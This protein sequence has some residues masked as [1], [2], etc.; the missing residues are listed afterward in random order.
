MA[1]ESA[2]AQDFDKNPENPLVN[3]FLHYLIGLEQSTF[4]AEYAYPLSLEPMGGV[5]NGLTELLAIDQGGHFLALERVY[6]IRGFEVKLFQLATGGAMDISTLPSL[7]S[8]ENLNPIQKQLVL[9]FSTL[10][11]PVDAVD[12]L[13]A[14]TLG[15][16]LPDGSASL[17]LMSDDNF[18]DDQE[19]QV[20][21]FRLAIA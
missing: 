16:P 1:T 10:D 21:L 9:D 20:W 5:V 8:I 17:W 13:E 11:L 19:T 2:L 6:G 3:R 14:M 15:P 18:S 7:P 12:N 4:I